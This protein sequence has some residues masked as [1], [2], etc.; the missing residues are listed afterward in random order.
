MNAEGLSPPKRCGPFSVDWVRQWLVRLGLTQHKGN[1]SLG[2]HEWWPADLSAKLGVGEATVQRWLRC[3]WLHGRQVGMQHIWV[4]WADAAEL[5]RLRRLRAW[6]A[7]HGKS[8]IPE[9]LKTP[10]RADK[11]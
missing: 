10:K 7:R 2:R 4:A 3:G 6:Q 11:E 8:N 1:V 9:E 5:R